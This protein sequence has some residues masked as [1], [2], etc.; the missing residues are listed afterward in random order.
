MQALYQYH[1]S[2]AYW[3]GTGTLLPE[4]ARGASGSTSYPGLGGLGRVQVSTLSFGIAPRG[5]F[6]LAPNFGQKI[7]PSLSEA[8]FVF[9]LHL[10]LAKKLDQISVKTFFFVL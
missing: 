4:P 10:I 1:R 6:R 8:L 2:T 5:V 3:V 7:G 9:A